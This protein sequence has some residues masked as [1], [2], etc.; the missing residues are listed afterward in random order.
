MALVSIVPNPVLAEV[1]SKPPFGR[2]VDVQVRPDLFAGIRESGRYSGIAPWKAA[3]IGAW[4]A[5]FGS[6]SHVRVGLWPSASQ[7]FTV[8][9]I[10]DLGAEGTLL[11][12]SHRPDSKGRART[13]G[14]STVG[15]ALAGWV[16]FRGE[17]PPPIRVATL[18]TEPGGL[19]PPLARGRGLL[20]LNA[21]E[22]GSLPTAL[23]A[24]LEH[25]PMPTAEY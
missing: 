5:R 17:L 11:L 24:V 2:A 15:R 1:A 9:A 7:H 12:A 18:A 3:E 6:S 13:L 20:P 10:V 21:R 19:F 16:R 4:L 22:H 25:P 14:M 8:C 23:K